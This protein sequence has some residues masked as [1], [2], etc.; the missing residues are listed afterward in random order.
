VLRML[1]SDSVGVEVGT[2]R[3]DFAARILKTAE[4]RTLHLVDPWLVS[5]E[6]DRAD[7]AW[8]GT[9]RVS[10]REMDEIHDAVV[11]RFGREIAAGRVVVH[12]EGATTALRSMA[13]ASVDYVYVDGDHS[14]AAVV[15]DLAESFRVARPGGLICC[16]DYM[17][18][19]WWGDGVVRAVHEFLAAK[20]VIIEAKAGSQMVIRK[21]R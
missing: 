8:Y 13:P 20:P 9:G 16:D 18:G 6:E 7:R 5:D 2:W 19:S 4:P 15:A 21:L 3:G 12:R 14:Y 10:Q 17:L 11:G 1:P